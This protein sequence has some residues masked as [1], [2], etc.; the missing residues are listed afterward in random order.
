M[1]WVRGAMDNA[2]DYGSEDSRFESWRAR[3]AH[4][5][6][7]FHHLP[8]SSTSQSIATD[9]HFLLTHHSPTALPASSALVA[10]R[11]DSVCM[12]GIHCTFGL[13]HCNT[14]WPQALA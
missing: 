7:L 6:S 2:S 12:D 9:D 13:A 11:V 10:L 14:R 5:C 1:K 8:P 3:L 4:I